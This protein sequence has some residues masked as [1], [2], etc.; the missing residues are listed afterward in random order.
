MKNTYRNAKKASEI[1]ISHEIYSNNNWKTC[2]KCLKLR[3]V[4]EIFQLQC[5]LDK[6]SYSH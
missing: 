4:K 6:H 5:S 3:P 2:I 1:L